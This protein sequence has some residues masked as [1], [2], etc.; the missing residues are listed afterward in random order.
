MLI[1]RG[2][3]IVSNLI[4]SLTSF[5]KSL[6]NSVSEDLLSRLYSSQ[7]VPSII[8]DAIEGSSQA[9]LG[10]RIRLMSHG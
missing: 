9:I 3:Q 10:I 1:L 5:I 7:I 2:K 8:H 6:I 4:A